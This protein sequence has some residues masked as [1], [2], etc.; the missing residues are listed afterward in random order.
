MI[1]KG[2]TVERGVLP[3]EGCLDAKEFL[4]EIARRG[5]EII[6][7]EETTRRLTEETFK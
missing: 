7:T 2:K 5:I 6:E 1:A 3:P 4:R